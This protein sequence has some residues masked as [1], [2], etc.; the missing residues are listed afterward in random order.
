MAEIRRTP[1]AEADL[2][3]ILEDLQRNNPASA[4]RYTTAFYDKGQM[5]ARF[6]EIGRSRPEI[7]PNLRSTLVHPYVIFYRFEDDLVQI[8]RILHGKRDLRS[9]M[10][11]ESGE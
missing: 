11:A 8:L 3:T 7:A 6:P 9:I 2:E 10:R 5:L 1:Q 4:E